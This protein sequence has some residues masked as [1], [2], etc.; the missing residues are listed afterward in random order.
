[1]LRNKI[2]ENSDLLRE[3]IMFEMGKTWEGSEEDLTSITSSLKY[4][5]QE[6]QERKDIPLVDKE[7]THEHRIVSQPLGVAVAFLAY[8]FPLLNLG[9]KLGPALA[10]GCNIILKPSEF[11]PLSAYII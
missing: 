2:L 4:Y 6:I 8:N 7:G 1:K 9:F 10:A 5:A 11:S 3:S